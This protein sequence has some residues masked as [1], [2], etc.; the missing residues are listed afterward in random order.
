MIGLLVLCGRASGR[1]R[2]AEPWL[3]GARPKAAGP[4]D[5]RPSAALQAFGAKP[6]SCSDAP[7]LYAI[8]LDVCSRAGM[9]RL[10][11]LFLL[12]TS[13]M[14][15][16][17]L[18]S[19]ND[20]CISVTQGLLSGLS[21]DEIAGILAHEVAH[22]L[23][24]DTGAMHWAA[25]VQNEIVASAS[26]GMAAMRARPSASVDAGPRAL[27]LA[28]APAVANLLVL[29]LSRLREFA[30]DA[31]ALELIDDPQMLVAALCKL[32]YFHTGRSP[33]HAH[34]QED[35]LSASHR[36]HPGTWERIVNLA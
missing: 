32:E 18:G 13:G 10:P 26:Q 29:A 12:P 4:A 21:R 27:L 16:Y 8:L 5:V 9:K 31:M 30:A 25:A 36:S 34:L 20:A 19:P 22:I 3:A 24:H 33:L 17:A 14:N 11:E 7:G 35:A 15:A 23:H 1:S 2:T 28:A 6:L